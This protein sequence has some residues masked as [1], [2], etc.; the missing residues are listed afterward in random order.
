MRKKYSFAEQVAIAKVYEDKLFTYYETLP[1]IV[2][3]INCTKDK[4][5][6]KLDIDFITVKEYSNIA[7]AETLEVKID[8]RV[9]ETGNLFVEMGDKGW[10]NKSKAERLLY[11]DA[12]SKIGYN[13]PMC[14]LRE[15][16]REHEEEFESKEV[17]TS[18]FGG[19]NITGLLVPLEQLLTEPI[20]IT[21]DLTEA[22]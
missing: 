12:E 2:K 16:V 8:F 5:F 18:D 22:I 3:V 1:S 4:A 9:K 17:Y 15:Y 13:I 10:L 21:E 7:R 11:V 19:F 14:W 6:Q 20:V